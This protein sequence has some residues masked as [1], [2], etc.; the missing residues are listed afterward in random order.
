[1]EALI[2]TRDLLV[3]TLLNLFLLA[4]CLLLIE[5][6]RRL[7]ARGRGRKR[8]KARE[9]PEDRE[10]LRRDGHLLPF[11]RTKEGRPTYHDTG[12]PG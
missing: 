10:R 4:C 12:R 9:P 7:W 1:M 3:L 5:G 2:Y 6:C 8:P 11:G